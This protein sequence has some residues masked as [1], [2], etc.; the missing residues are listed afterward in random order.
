MPTRSYPTEKEHRKAALDLYEKLT[1]RSNAP[2]TFTPR[3]QLRALQSA[4]QDVLDAWV[5]RSKF[6]V[7]PVSGEI[8]LPGLRTFR[9]I[10]F[11]RSTI[12]PQ[13]RKLVFDRCHFQ[14]TRIEFPEG[15]GVLTL[16]R[17][18]GEHLDV[19]TLDTFHVFQSSIEGLETQG[20]R[21]TLRIQASAL[22][23]LLV[24]KATLVDDESL[25]EN[26]FL[27]EAQLMHLSAE[28]PLRI[29]ACHLEGAKVSALNAVIKL[30][31]QKGALACLI[32]AGKS[33]TP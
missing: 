27:E 8:A 18:T 7:Y 20:V 26:S 10:T 6:P 21:G 11:Y 33:S 22:P 23:R 12:R 31:E 1:G 32:Q 16:Q 3:D 30:T 14:N 4:P 13:G 25:I 5:L 17:C 28:R 9:G 19:G 15:N 24:E 2:P 29:H